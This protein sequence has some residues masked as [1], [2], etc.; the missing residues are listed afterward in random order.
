VSGKK[1][2]QKIKD[3]L[4]YPKIE[5]HAK[6]FFKNI[7]KQG[8]SAKNLLTFNSDKKHLS[9]FQERLCACL[10]AFCQGH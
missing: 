2:P 4:K 5:T 10:F 1:K 7:L 8:L 9:E 3:T 6:Q